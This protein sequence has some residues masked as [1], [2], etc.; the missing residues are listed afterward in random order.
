MSKIKSPT[1]HE[2]R[3]TVLVSIFVILQ[4]VYLMLMFSVAYSFFA[5][6]AVITACLFCILLSDGSR[7]YCWM[8]IGLSATVCAD[9]FLVFLPFQLRVPG[10]L[11]FCVTQT[12]YFLRVYSEDENRL[13]KRI[14]LILRV[15][16]SVFSL[17]V[18]LLILGIRADTLSLIS[19]FYYANLALN[20]LFSYL[21]FKKLR[22]LAIAF[23]LF[24]LSDTLIGFDCLSSYLLIP[25]GSVVYLITKLGSRFV[26]PLYLA[27][28][29]LIPLSLLK[30]KKIALQKEEA[31]G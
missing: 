2:K 11:C 13:R 24:I 22:V 21:Q 29:T 9:F 28:Q 12:A 23:S 31:N 15:A 19:V 27:A 25:R 30:R 16:V 10:V 8:Q 5:Y 17:A 7:A 18:A 3:L 14:H 6:V 20:L 1:K 26:M 4:I